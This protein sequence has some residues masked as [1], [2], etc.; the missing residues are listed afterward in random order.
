MCRWELIYPSYLQNQELGQSSYSARKKW[1]IH[2]DWENTS[3]LLNV[4]TIVPLI[5]L[6][7]LDTFSLCHCQAHMLSL[8]TT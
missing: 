4:L 8:E 7:F 3:A 2:A 5:S 6:D 1:H